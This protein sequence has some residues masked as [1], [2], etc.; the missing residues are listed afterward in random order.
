MRI[1]KTNSK[2]IENLELHNRSKNLEILLVEK[3]ITNTNLKPSLKMKSQPPLC[4]AAIRVEVYNHHQSFVSH[5]W[6]GRNRCR[7]RS[8]NTFYPEHCLKLGPKYL[9]CGALLQT[10]PKISCLQDNIFIYDKI[11]QQ[12]VCLP[13]VDLKF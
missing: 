3:N 4:S 13:L 7:N 1:V 2:P 8:S 6:L 10:R 5:R 9:L 11:F 12:T